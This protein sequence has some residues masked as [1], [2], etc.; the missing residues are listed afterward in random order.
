L[1]FSVIIGA[2]GWHFHVLDQ[3]NKDLVST[4]LLLNERSNEALGKVVLE[5]CFGLEHEIMELSWEG[6]LPLLAQ[7]KRIEDQVHALDEKLISAKNGQELLAV[8]QEVV[9]D[10]VTVQKLMVES[11]ETNFELWEDHLRET[12]DRLDKLSQQDLFPKAPNKISTEDQ[13]RFIWLQ[14]MV[15]QH[16]LLSCLDLVNELGMLIKRPC[17]AFEQRFPIVNRPDIVSVG[18]PAKFRI[19]AGT[20]T[21]SNQPENVSF[22]VNGKTYHPGYDGVLEYE[23]IPAGRGK[24]QLDVR[25]EITNPLTGEVRT[26]QAIHTYTVK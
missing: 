15:K 23:F 13:E 4:S 12:I 25:L 6:Y 21:V 11:H 10:L 1:G 9:G 8:T 5:S 14:A 7:L 19:M 16:F 18:Q 20:Y 3:H 24:Q 26:S 17:F 2:I 22:I